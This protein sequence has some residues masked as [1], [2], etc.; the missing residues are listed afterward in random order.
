MSALWVV[1]LFM[2][3]IIITAMIR[4]LTDEAIGW[5]VRIPFL[6]LQIAAWRVPKARREELH[7]DWKADL[8]VALQDKTEHPVTR[9]LFGIHFSASLIRGSQKVARELDTTRPDEA[10]V[11]PPLNNAPAL[12]GI[13]PALNSKPLRHARLADDVDAIIDKIDYVLEENAEEFVRSYVQKPGKRW[14]TVP[15]STVT[16]LPPLPLT[17]A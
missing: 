6:L 12:Q 14:N 16:G 8:A 1:L 13:S 15:L 10:D 9:L 3:G 2:A 7:Q 11:S 17:S 5:I 4:L